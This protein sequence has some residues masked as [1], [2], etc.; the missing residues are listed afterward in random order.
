MTTTKPDAVQYAQ[1]GLSK[2][3]VKD[4]VAEGKVNTLPDGPSRTVRE[5]VRSNIITRFNILIAAL[6]VVSI[7]VAPLQ[8]SLFAGVMIINTIIGIYQE[9]KAKRTLDRLALLAAPKARVVRGGKVQEIDVSTVVIQDV[10]EVGPGDQ[11]VVDGQVLTTSNLEVDESLLTGESDAIEKAPGD[12]VL[13]GSF[14][15]AGGG[16]FMA[17]KVG[18]DA[19]A[20]QLAEQAKVFTLV[21][22]ELRSGID[23]I[24][25]LVSW[26]IIPTAVL[27]VYSQLNASESLKQALQGA[28]AGVVAMVPQGLVLVTSVAF[29]VGV[30]RLGRRDVLV[31]EL[32][33][34]EGLARVDV[35]CLDKTGTLTY[36]RL[37]VDGVQAITGEDYDAPL[38][39][40]AQADPNPNATQAAIAAAFAAPEGWTAT[41]T[42]PFSSARKW[43]GATFAGRGTY[44]LGAPEVVLG[45][46][47][48]EAARR[49]DL[50]ALEGSRVILLARS[51]DPLRGDVLPANL[52]PVA[53]VL[54]AD[55]IKPEAPE[56][57]AFFAAQDV[58]I[59]VISGDHPRTVGRIAQEA[60]VPER[61]D[62]VDARSLPQDPG[63]LADVMES[64]S[65]FGRV[66]PQQK[67]AMIEALQS[68]GHVVAMTGDGVNDVLALKS[69]DI[70]IAMGS[71]S[72]ASRSVAQLV[73]LDSSFATVPQVVAEGRRVIANIERVANLYLTKTVYAFL[74]ALAIGV[75]GWQF[76]FLPRHLTL[77]GTLTIGA[78]SFFLALAPSARRA[79]TGFVKRVVRFSAPAGLLAAAA[80]FVAYW[81]ARDQPDVALDEARTTATLVLVLVGLF[82]LAVISRPFNPARR[83]LILSMGLILALVFAIPASRVFFALDFPPMIVLTSAVGVAS[84]TGALMFASLRAV[85]WTVMAPQVLRSRRV[86]RLEQKVEVRLQEVEMGIES[87]LQRT[88][89]SIR[90]I[91]SGKDDLEE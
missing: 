65:V 53:F 59:K 51:V 56:I 78:P 25:K 13:S 60:G 28:V 7:L 4:R 35:V 85:E 61:G 44:V 49:A 86:Q 52:E 72:G 55:Q 82:I 88:W 3:Q 68:R 42:V 30:V 39:A 9:L 15:S 2:R 14:V 21:R 26:L 29:A 12:E 89:R 17:T 54:L 80:T 32:P 70:G 87:W 45:G 75:A 63:A 90:A 62:P 58:S 77:I 81:L 20:A 66:T 46:Q 73:L 22:S 69:A 6:L 11:I 79:T 38:G 84:M 34:L 41:A 50:L 27:L 23:W 10:L 47:A 48:S 71:G 67:R 40:L 83:T 57:L 74:L 33:A 64:R 31:Q 76:P 24:L 8:D 43:S 91:F 16:R 5:I 37:A 1:T 18:R 36:G 19:Y